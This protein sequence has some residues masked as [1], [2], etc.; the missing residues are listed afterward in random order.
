MLDCC[1]VVVMTGQRV[2]TDSVDTSSRG[3]MLPTMR[4]NRF[5]GSVRQAWPKSLHAVVALWVRKRET[6]RI[7]VLP[8]KV[9]SAS[10]ETSHRKQVL[11]RYALTVKTKPS[12]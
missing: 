1:D 12:Y 7:G 5:A 3:S 10:D 11:G 8:V 9:C 2:D 6:I 4:L